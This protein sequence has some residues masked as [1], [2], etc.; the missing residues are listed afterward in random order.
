M[1]TLANINTW[2]QRARPN[3]TIEAFSVQLGC[4]LEE[5]AEMLLVL[6]CENERGDDEC[7]DAYHTLC[8]LSDALKKGELKAVLKSEYRTEFLD[9][10]ADQIV[11]A[12]GAGHCASMNVVEACKV[13]DLSNWSKL[14]K[15]GQ[16][17]FDANGK[18]TKGLGYMPPDLRGLV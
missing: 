15:D 7:A 9:S 13:V 3:P 5:I 6:R 4:H 1:N 18:I 2:H 10:L 12:V 11:T 16:P 14:D 8:S 17:V